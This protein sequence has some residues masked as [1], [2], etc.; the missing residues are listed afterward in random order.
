MAP[1]APGFKKKKWTY[2]K[3]LRFQ[4]KNFETTSFN[5][6]SFIQNQILSLF[7]DPVLSV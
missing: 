7:G 3:L 5:L 4:T 6:L 1:P 2:F